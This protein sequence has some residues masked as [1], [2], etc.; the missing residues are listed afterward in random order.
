MGCL[1]LTYQTSESPLKVVYR[2]VGETEKP[3]QRFISLDPLA[4]KYP[5]NGSYNF[6]EN[7]VIDGIELEG[8]EFSKKKYN[9]NL[10][11]VPHYNYFIS[12]TESTILFFMA[13][14]PDT[15]NQQFTYNRNYPK[16]VLD[17]KSVTLTFEAKLYS[18]ADT[19]IKVYRVKNNG[20]KKEV[21]SGVLTGKTTLT[22]PEIKLRR[23]NKTLIVETNLVNKQTEEDK[24]NGT[25]ETYEQE[26]SSTSVE[27]TVKPKSMLK[28]NVKAK[29]K[30]TEREI[31]NREKSGV[32]TDVQ[33]LN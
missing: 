25:N 27:V 15:P 11:S 17:Y 8:L 21:F 6:S 9:H 14:F 16:D 20:K 24:G 19:E 4:A 31:K 13:M 7:R 23:N 28:M 26:N 1:R 10:L 30:A 2:A 29:V 33:K 32:I 12:E 22:T 5:Y 18:N 3:L